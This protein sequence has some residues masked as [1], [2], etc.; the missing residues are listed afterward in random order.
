MP[1]QHEQSAALGTIFCCNDW[2][3]CVFAA[4][5]RNYCTSEI[6]IEIAKETPVVVVLVDVDDVPMDGVS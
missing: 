5:Y 4:I 3:S 1:G 2:L 6:E